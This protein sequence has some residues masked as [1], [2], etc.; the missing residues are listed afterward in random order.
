MEE[1]A[2]IESVLL[3]LIIMIP[4]MVSFI[5]LVASFS[6]R[7]ARNWLS[8][9]ATGVPFVLLLWLFPVLNRGTEV[10]YEIDSVV[11]LGLNFS[12]DALSYIFALVV[13]LV[14]FL[15]TLYLENYINMEEHQE[16]FYFFLVLT[17]SGALGTVMTTN[18]FTLY[19]FFELMSIASYAL[20]VHEQDVFAIKA[21]TKYLY[22]AVCGGL[23]LL[24]AI[25]LVYH[26]AGTAEM[27]SVVESFP[28]TGIKYIIVLAFAIGF[29]T[30][31]GMFP[32]HIWLPDA[33]PVAPT[34]ASA[35]LSGIMVKMGVYG[36][37]R[38]LNVMIIPG[39][40]ETVYGVFAENIGFI[41]IW[42][43]IITMVLGALLAIF[44]Q[45]MKKILAYSTISQ[46]GYII[47]ALGVASYMGLEEPI[48]L[49]AALFH[50]LNHA[51]F[52]SALFLIVG[53]IYYRTHEL[54]INRLSGLVHKMPFATTAFMIGTAG[55][56]A[57]PG[58]NGFVSKIMLHEA[59]LEAYHF[60]GNKMLY[61]AEKI[62][63]I[64]GVLTATY[65]S[66]ILFTIFWGKMSRTV[67]D[68]KKARVGKMQTGV[69]ILCVL[70]ILAGLF[71]GYV[72]RL[73]IVPA[74]ESLQLGHLDHVPEYIG[75]LF[76]LKNIKSALYTILGGFLFYFL[77]NF[78]NI[79]S[80]QAN[81]N[82]SIERLVY[83]PL[84]FMFISFS[85]IFTIIFD[86]Y[87]TR[88]YYLIPSAFKKINQ[89]F[90]LVMDTEVTKSYYFF[91][92]I[93]SKIN[94]VFIS[95]FDKK[96]T[97]SYDNVPH[98]FSK[99][100]NL[101]ISPKSVQDSLNNHFQQ[102]N[103]NIKNLDFDLYIL[104]LVLLVVLI[105]MLPGNYILF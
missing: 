60:Q 66:K 79:L 15:T 48:G 36:L 56:I 61:Y 101:F 58:L 67:A 100:N 10:I 27:V 86:R 74:L 18:L 13:S 103:W 92:T 70:I 55:I 12:L 28:R 84:V 38:V 29:G 65:F 69:G 1:T 6:S 102:I 49:T 68:M 64:N 71:P 35:L 94:Q 2:V 45:N 26:Y 53:I 99:I 59:I 4:L 19:I 3:P 87:L 81:K 82:L 31:A 97:H 8:V 52:K 21:A 11:N 14:W 16:R 47:M 85:E 33:H 57:V 63:K 9:L 54:N 37:L 96:V 83:R 62:F 7:K 23:S 89:V 24:L 77:L 72:S 95:V 32:L 104:V 5:I 90:V 40:M 50:V 51:L 105:V 30:K 80:F 73:L 39:D 42:L 76:V 20:I 43:G 93:F 25:F 17:L 88:G 34:P 44:Q 41:T 98:V 91:P 46:V 75:H 22:M 78:G